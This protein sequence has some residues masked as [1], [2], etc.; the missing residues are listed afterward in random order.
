MNEIKLKPCP[1]CGGDAKFEIAKDVFCNPEKGYIFVRCSKCNAKSDN[2]ESNVYVC[3]AEEAAQA[4]NNR[5]EIFK[6]GEWK[7]ANS[8]KDENGDLTNMY[9]CSCCNIILDKATDYCPNCGA[10]MNK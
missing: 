9:S 3:A 1:F 2:F 8:Y 10:K 6:H 7:T 5:N 4:W